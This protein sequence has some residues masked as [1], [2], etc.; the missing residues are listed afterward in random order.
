MNLESVKRLFVRP[1][2]GLLILRVGAGAIIALHG[3]NKF[4]GGT[5]TLE[6]VGSNIDAIGIAAPQGTMLPLFF[7]IMA[8]GAELGGGLL[9][10]IGWFTRPACILILFTMIVATAT[11]IPGA[12]LNVAQYGYPLL[13]ACV[14]LAILFAGPG[15]YSIQK[16]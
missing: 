6:R 3:F 10:L 7:G 5:G 13:F 15:R 16:E 8:A 11:K 4:A 2:L 14:A 1:D 9:W 12:G